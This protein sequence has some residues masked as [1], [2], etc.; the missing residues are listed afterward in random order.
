MP[1]LSVLAI[2]GLAIA[3]VSVAI[4]AEG[5]A[6]F[7]PRTTARLAGVAQQFCTHSCRRADG[8]CP[9]TDSSTCPLWKFVGAKL[10]TGIPVDPLI[11][12]GPGPSREEIPARKR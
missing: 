11:P 1:P 6:P 5:L 2:L 9:L 10:S 12:V 7:A 4:F 8:T 3:L